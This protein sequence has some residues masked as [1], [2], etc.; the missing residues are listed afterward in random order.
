ML[1]IFNIGLAEIF[2]SLQVP[3]RVRVCDRFLMRPEKCRPLNFPPTYF[4]VVI[5][6]TKKPLRVSSKL[7]CQCLKR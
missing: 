2:S 4:R 7:H 1:M 3:V 6:N 5:L